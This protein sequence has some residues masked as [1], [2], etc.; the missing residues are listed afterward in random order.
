M[1][2]DTV[3]NLY[4]YMYV[5]IYV[6]VHYMYKFMYVSSWQTPSALR[7]QFSKLTRISYQI[8]M[9]NLLKN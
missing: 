1:C 4:I 6:H 9:A 2:T 3:C 5:Y 8:S 7:L